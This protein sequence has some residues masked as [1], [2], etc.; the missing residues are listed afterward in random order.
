MLAHWVLVRGRIRQ[1][2]LCASSMVGRVPEPVSQG[3]GSFDDEGIAGGTP[4]GT[5][6]DSDAIQGWMKEAGNKRPGRAF[7]RHNMAGDIG[8]P[9]GRL[10][11]V[12]PTLPMPL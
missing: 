6:D 8:W 12:N 5:L 9:G 1:S 10:Q 4:L 2:A 11:G 7:T 3:H